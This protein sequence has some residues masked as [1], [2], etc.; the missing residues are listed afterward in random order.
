MSMQV[1]PVVLE[2]RWVRLE[3]LQLSHA[4]AL[5]S[6]C[7]DP[8]IWRYMPYKQPTAL[9]EMEGW[10]VLALDAQERGTDVPF[11]ILGCE[12]GQALGSTRYLNILPKDRGLEIGWTWLTGTAR[13]TSVNTECKYLL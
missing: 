13:R 3:P 5:Y 9:S 1:K 4:G 8:E 11:A 6:V 7:Q 10:I 12:T 2:G